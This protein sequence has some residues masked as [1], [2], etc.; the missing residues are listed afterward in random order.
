MEEQTAVTAEIAQHATHMVSEMDAMLLETR[1]NKQI[2]GAT[3]M[4]A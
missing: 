3:Y 4:A 1:R 2:E